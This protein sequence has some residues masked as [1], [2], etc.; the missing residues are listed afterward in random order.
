MFQKRRRKKVAPLKFIQGKSSTEIWNFNYFAFVVGW[1][2]R[3]KVFFSVRKIRHFLSFFLSFF[4]S[5]SA[6]DTQKI[7][8]ILN[9]FSRR[10]F[11]PV[12]H[13]FC[14]FLENTERKEKEKY[15]CGWFRMTRAATL[16]FFFLRIFS[17]NAV[18]IPS[19]RLDKLK[20]TFCIVPRTER[21][22]F[23]S[24][25]HERA[26]SSPPV[27]KIQRK[28]SWPYLFPAF[29][30]LKESNRVFP[31]PSIFLFLFLSLSLMMGKWLRRERE[32]RKKNHNHSLCT[33]FVCRRDC[34]YSPSYSLRG[35]ERERKENW[36]IE[37]VCIRNK[38]NW[39][40]T[41]N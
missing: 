31:L 10:F 18:F 4:P 8:P 7:L 26:R 34:L 25:H 39:G 37:P 2:T 30:F 15:I 20:S 13:F 14:F 12:I 32:R 1:Q 38:E 27:G 5:S 21:K 33:A 11:S 35:R 19:S 41:D 28:S 16:F 6:G 17:K 40:Q 29:D 23:C 22:R 9:R 36:F 24:L 3:K